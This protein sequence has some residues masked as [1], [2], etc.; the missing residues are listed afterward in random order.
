MHF[1][2]EFEHITKPWCWRLG[3]NAHSF[4]LV[5]QIKPTVDGEPKILYES[6]Y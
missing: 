2:L 5:L 6:I 3:A 1:Q 4:L